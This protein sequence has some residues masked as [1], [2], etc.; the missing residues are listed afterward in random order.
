MPVSSGA[1]G[2]RFRHPAPALN[3]IQSHLQNALR[4]RLP[5]SQDPPEI[6]TT[7]RGCSGFRS[8]RSLASGGSR[9]ILHVTLSP[10][11]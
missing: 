3:L 1:N 11:R 6:L 2:L 5:A 9:C 10:R 4:P 7:H 8:P